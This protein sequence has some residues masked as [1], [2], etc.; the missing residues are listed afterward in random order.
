[1]AYLHQQTYGRAVNKMRNANGRSRTQIDWDGLG[2]AIGSAIGGPKK[3]KPAPGKTAAGNIDAKQAFKED[4]TR[5]GK[6]PNPF[7]ATQADDQLNDQDQY[8]EFMRMTGSHP[9][10]KQEA[11]KLAV[12]KLASNQRTQDS[13]DKAAILSRMG[14]VHTT[15]G[16]Q[17]AEQNAHDNAQDRMRGR[18][19]IGL[20]GTMAGYQGRPPP[21]PEEIRLRNQLRNGGY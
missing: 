14:G 11:A 12:Q 19:L 9:G 3:P 5:N 17:L 15:E 20:G 4:E 1:M 7:E 2:G 13:V 8:A 18:A 21:T 16:L 10:L 6:V